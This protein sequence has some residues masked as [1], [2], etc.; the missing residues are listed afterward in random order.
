MEPYVLIGGESP[1]ELWSDYTNNVSQHRDE[2]EATI[3]G[4]DEARASRGPD[5]ELEGV[6]ARKF[7]VGC[8]WKARVSGR[9]PAWQR[10]E[11]VWKWC[12]NGVEMVAHLRIP[13]IG[14]EEQVGTVKED[15]EC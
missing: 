11:T 4:E 9:S 15:V 12:R 3:I 5:R 8:L 10:L 2:D 14:E 7:L 13:S 1:C 6:E